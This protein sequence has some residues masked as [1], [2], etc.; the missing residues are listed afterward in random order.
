MQETEGMWVQ[1]PG[2]EDPLEE[3]MAAHSRILAWRI[4]WTEQ[5][6]ELQPMGSQRVRHNWSNLACRIPLCTHTHS[7]TPHLLYM[8]IRW[9]TFRL[10]S[11][12]CLLWIL[13]PSLISV[14]H[15]FQTRVIPV[16]YDCCEK[17]EKAHKSN[18]E[19]CLLAIR[20]SL[21]C[22]HYYNCSTHSYD[23]ME[24]VFR[25]KCLDRPLYLVL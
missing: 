9:W 15:N 8:F 14:N 23:G 19:Q 25:V 13:A 22:Y 6:D 3:G 1:S 21:V 2:Q 16:I 5:P 24:G 10:F 18:L 11:M 12:S 17:F 4:P 20:H 7:H